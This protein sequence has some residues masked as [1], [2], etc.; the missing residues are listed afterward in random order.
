[1][2]FSETVQEL[3][4]TTTSKMGRKRIEVKIEPV[5]KKWLNKD[6]AASFL[7]CSERTLLRLRNKSL[8]RFTKYGNKIL[9]D[10]QSVERFL[11]RHRVN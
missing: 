6:E 1:M 3:I 5:Q 8:I 10:Y 2:T 11:E 9:Y 7:G 4:L